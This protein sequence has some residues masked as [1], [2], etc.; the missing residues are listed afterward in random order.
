LGERV[1]QTFRYYRDGSSGGNVTP[2]RCV[3]AHLSIAETP[4][5]VDGRGLHLDGKLADDAVNAVRI[6]S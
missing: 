4:P 5:V 6:Q 1:R 3:L 2:G